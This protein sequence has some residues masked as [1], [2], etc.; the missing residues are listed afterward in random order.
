MRHDVGRQVDR[1]IA[2][3]LHSFGRGN[4]GL[5]QQ[6]DLAFGGIT[7]LHI[8]RHVVATD[9]EIFNGLGGHQVFACVGVNYGLK[10]GFEGLFCD[11]HGFSCEGA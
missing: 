9:A 1:H 8:K 6:R 2:H 7:Q 10:R 5:T 4:Q 3:P 11:R